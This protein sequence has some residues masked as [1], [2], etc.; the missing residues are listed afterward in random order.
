MIIWVGFNYLYRVKR[1]CHEIIL[2]HDSP[3]FCN[4]SINENENKVIFYYD[5]KLKRACE[6][7][8]ET[9]Y[10]NK[11]NKYWK[12]H[13]LLRDIQNK[14]YLYQNENFN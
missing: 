13:R 1:G 7:M 5:R 11:N 4:E 14:L 10:V 9:E 6:K 2:F 3:L 12:I 8:V